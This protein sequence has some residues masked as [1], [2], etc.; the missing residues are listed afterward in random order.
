MKISPKLRAEIYKSI[1][2]H[3]FNMHC[4][5]DEKDRKDEISHS[6]WRELFETV[7]KEKS[8]MVEEIFQKI[9]S[10]RGKR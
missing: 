6:V 10:Y 8:L 5:L 4:A 7:S 1:S 3:I 9:E 2:D